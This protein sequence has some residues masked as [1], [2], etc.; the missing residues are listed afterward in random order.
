M[1]G[2]PSKE[3]NQLNEFLF[4]LHEMTSFEELFKSIIGFTKYFLN[5]QY[6]S[7][8]DFNLQSNSLV[9]I[10]GNFPDK[11]LENKFLL[12]GS[13]EINLNQNSAH[14][15][16]I[17]KKKSI[18]LYK[19]NKKNIN[20]PNEFK[21]Q[22][23]LNL[24]SLLINPIFLKGNLIG[25]LDFSNFFDKITLSKNQVYYI[26]IFCKMLGGTLKLFKTNYEL[27]QEKNF[28]KASQKKVEELTEV[29]KIQNQLLEDQKD[30]VTKA[31]F[32][33]EESQK[34]LIQ[35]DKLITLGTLVAGVAHEIN[36]PLGAIKVSSENISES[37]KDLFKKLNPKEMNLNS[38]DIENITYIVNISKS[39]S[40]SGSTRELR[41]VKK[42]IYSLL[43]ADKNP[44]SDLISEFIF[45]LGLIDQ[46]ENHDPI[47]NH[48]NIVIYLSIANDLLGIKK[49]SNIITASAEK[50]SKIVKS[51]KSYIHFEQREEMILSNIIDGIETIL[52]ILNNKIKYGIEVIKKY[53]D[54]PLTYCYPDELN[55]I[56]TNLIHNAIQAM[57]EKGEIL[58]EVSKLTKLY[59]NFDIDKI[60]R[61]FQGD[62]FSVSI[63]DTG[64]GIPAEVRPKIFEA[65]FTTK[66]AGEGSGLGLHIV[67]KI[68][69]KHN[70]G[71]LLESEPGSTRFTIVLPIK[72]HLSN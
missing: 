57:N 5:L 17:D 40:F 20:N 58:I 54:I 43:E 27:E 29:L 42:K 1:N 11:N 21:N 56:W 70:G 66:P 12:N 59:S 61:N 36:T 15:L 62:Y 63:H 16:A 53:E 3:L 60:D 18:Y 19:I 49:K 23:L 50:V 38:S 51:L 31:Y 34:I 39:F 2:I 28:A 48:K 7:Y 68:L 25:V 14:R 45:E 9:Y 32:D 6:C 10:L 52:I 41:A 55:Q 8:W 71:L 26:S 47:F 13:K 22:E 30:R 35:S 67:G 37:L 72:V 44:K 69:E 46:L 24:N 65:F 4:T 33:L 64:S